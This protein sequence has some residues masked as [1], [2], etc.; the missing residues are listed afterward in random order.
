MLSVDSDRVWQQ[1]GSTDPYFGVVSEERFRRGR[2]DDRAREEFLRS[3]L[4]HVESVRRTIVEHVDP[5]FHPN[6]ALDFGCGVGRLAIGLARISREVVG[7]D[8]SRAMLDEARRNC[9]ERGVANAAF[10]LCDDRL[11][12]L[13]RPFDLIHSYI[14]FQHIP[15][16]RGLR[17]LRRLLELLRPNGVGALH[18]TF[19]RR[20]SLGER[21]AYWFRARVPLVNEVVNVLRGRPWRHPMMQMN[22]YD[23]G[24]ICATL[25]EHG[26]TVLHLQLTDHEGH[27]GAMV[28]FQKR[29]AAQGDP[30]E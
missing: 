20:A 11:T 18:F 24:S 3:G 26:C 28:Y 6:R 10:R 5:E 9:R 7:V 27:L 19:W 16:R 23:L 25:F 4:E 30:I 8:I 14:V 2:L 22:D 1:Y 15:R 21:L 13:A 29:A 12:T 17:I